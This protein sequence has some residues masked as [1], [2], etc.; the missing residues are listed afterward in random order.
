[1]PVRLSGKV[2]EACKE[3]VLPFHIPFIAD[4]DLIT[5]MPPVCSAHPSWSL[6]S[7]ILR[8]QC[9][10]SCIYSF[11]Y[12]RALSFCV[13]MERKG[14]G[15]VVERGVDKMPTVS[16]DGRVGVSQRRV[17]GSH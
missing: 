13:H 5:P 10:K 9:N 4:R 6:S 17:G 8:V 1:M 14:G 3:N 11:Y 2:E 12:M 7:C 15:R 16:K